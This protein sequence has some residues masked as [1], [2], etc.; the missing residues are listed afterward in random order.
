MAVDESMEAHYDATRIFVEQGEPSN[1]TPAE[2]LEVC[3]N[4]EDM[5]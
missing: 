2:E 4:V 3:L 1:L 5:G